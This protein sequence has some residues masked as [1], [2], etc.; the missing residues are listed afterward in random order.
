MLTRRDYLAT[1]LA[2]SVGACLPRMAAAQGVAARPPVGPAWP[3]MSTGS[4]VSADGTSIRYRAGGRGD[5]TVLMVHGASCNHRFFSAQFATLAQHYRVVALDLAGHGGSGSRAEHSVEAFA[6]DVDAVA[7]T[8]DGPLVLLV[9][10]AG[11]RVA[12]AAAQPLGDRL[13]GIVGIDCFQNLAMPRPDP[14]RVEA[15][16]TMMRHD[17][18]AYIDGAMQFFFPEGSDPQ[19]VAWVAAQM[20]ATEPAQAAAAAQAYA[21]FD[22]KAAIA[23]FDRPLLALN[24]D[25]VRTDE[26][27][28]RELVPGFRARIFPGQGHFLH[29]AHW[30]SFNTVLMD[31]L[32]AITRA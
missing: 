14:A 11:G 27:V 31:S 23:G 5:V 10:S 18:R 8:F 4:I 12:C 28:I 24:A 25:G 29:L 13:R 19:L 9:H 6:A 7:G 20:S 2:L 30:E 3:E 26:A 1:T 17:F 22:E 15:V 16:L 32:V 21:D